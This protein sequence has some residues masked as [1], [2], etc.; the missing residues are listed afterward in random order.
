LEKNYLNQMFSFANK[1]CV[2]RCDILSSH[3]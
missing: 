3:T 1:S 2:T